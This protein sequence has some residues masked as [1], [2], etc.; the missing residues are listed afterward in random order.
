MILTLPGA[1]TTVVG[2][3]EN[4]L[5]KIVFALLI[6]SC[7]DGIF[8]AIFPALCLA[9]LPHLQDTKRN[10]EKLNVRLLSGIGKN[11]SRSTCSVGS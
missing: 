3:V 10:N 7:V 4:S 1:E 8:S 11:T 9:A 5:L 2:S 6:N